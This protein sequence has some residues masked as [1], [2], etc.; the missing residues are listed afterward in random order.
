VPNPEDSRIAITGLAEQHP[1]VILCVTTSACVLTKEITTGKNIPVV[2]VAVTDPIQAGLVADFTE[3]GEYITGVASTPK[4]AV[5]EG[6]GLE[7]LL[8]I[9][10]DI[11][12]IYIPHNPDE[13]A[14]S[15]RLA[16]V[17]EVATGLDIEIVTTD[18]RTEEEVLAAF[19]NIPA[20]ADAVITFAE[21][22]FTPPAMAELTQ[23]TIERKVPQLSFSVDYGQL[24]AYRPNEVEIGAVGAHLTDRILK[25]TKAS[26][27]P[28]ETPEFHLNINLDT[29]EAIHLTI[30]DYILRQAVIVRSNTTDNQ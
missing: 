19:T 15:R 4:N 28:V 3:T 26:D 17:Q 8:E 2:F 9:A 24:I 16:V 29:A 20:D 1:D 7:W 13:L 25:G 30:E 21:G 6:R 5:S 12:R 18:V 14:S 22:V 11:K 27:L 23:A 10:P